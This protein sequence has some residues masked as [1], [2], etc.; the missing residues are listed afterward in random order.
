MEALIPTATSFPFERD[1]FLKEENNRLYSV[2]PYFISKCILYI[3][4]TIVIPIIYSLII[5]W[6]VDLSSTAEQFFLFYLTVCMVSLSGNSIGLLIGSLVDSAK[7]VSI[8]TT[9]FFLPFILVSGFFKNFDSMPAWFGWFQYINPFKYT[10]ICLTIN[11]VKHRESNIND[12]NFD[13]EFW[14]CIG[15]LGALA[16]GYRLLSLFYLWYLR[17]TME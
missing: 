10:F 1:V 16:V 3:P 4:Y 12:L 8:A 5:Y 6:M 17:K 7:S 14:P 11:E 2:F 13:L 9:L 15:L